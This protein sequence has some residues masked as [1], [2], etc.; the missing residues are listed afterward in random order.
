[1]QNELCNQCFLKEQCE[2]SCP[3][4]LALNKICKIQLAEQK[5]A[6][7]NKYAQ[8]IGLIKY[9]IAPDLEELGQKVLD[10]F[11]EFAHIKNNGVRIGYLKS[12]DRK[13]SNGKS[14]L[15]ECRIIKGVYT[16]YLPFDFIITFFLPSVHGMS[17]NQIKLIMLHELKH[18][19]LNHKGYYLVPHD[20][21]DFRDIL[22]K[23]GLSWSQVNSDVPDILNSD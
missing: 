5:T 6:L 9:E 7:I 2:I 14:T 8:E 16:A 22:S 10:H 18:I 21:E 17:D 13:Q 23:Y 19:G 4:L 3:A 15:A 12:Y 20:I 11:P 1:M